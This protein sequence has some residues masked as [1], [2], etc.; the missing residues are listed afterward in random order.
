M[1]STFFSLHGIGKLLETFDLL[2]Q[3]SNHHIEPACSSRFIRLLME[4]PA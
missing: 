1:D 2:T 3:K 4:A